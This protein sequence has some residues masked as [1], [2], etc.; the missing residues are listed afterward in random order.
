MLDKCT[1]QFVFRWSVLLVAVGEA[2]WAVTWLVKGQLP[3]TDTI[4]MTG[5]GA[6]EKL[7][8][9]LPRLVDPLAAI[10]P[11]GLLIWLGFASV[12]F[13]IP[14]VGSHTEVS[15]ESN[16][17]WG[18]AA[19]LCGG[20]VIAFSGLAGLAVGTI[21][22]SAVILFWGSLGGYPPGGHFWSSSWPCW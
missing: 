11:M 13:R 20:L 22:S 17:F 7:F 6:T 15:G 19:G 9:A 4:L 8:Y 2:T 16:Y 18:L 12:N 3:V 10:V 14:K 5:G 21:I 1:R